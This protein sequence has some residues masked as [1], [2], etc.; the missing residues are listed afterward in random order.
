MPR[1]WTDFQSLELVI[2]QMRKEG[3]TRRQ[4]ADALGL[5]KIQ[6][7]NW[8]NR[9][10]RRQTKLPASPKRKGRQRKNPLNDQD[11]MALRIKELE[12]EVELYRS[13]LQAAGRM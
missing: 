13:F 12:R 9:Y 11:E 6:I 4:I 1:K 5:D 10:N 8:I 2:M 3:R 7:K